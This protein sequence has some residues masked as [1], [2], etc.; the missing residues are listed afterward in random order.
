MSTLTRKW[1]SSSEIAQMSGFSDRYVRRA[2]CFD[3]WRV[4]RPGQH[5]H[6]KHHRFVNDPE[7]RDFCEY[8]LAVNLRPGDHR[9]R[10]WKRYAGKPG[11]GLRPFHKLHQSADDLTGKANAL[12]AIG[13]L[14]ELKEELLDAVKRHPGRD[15]TKLRRE[16]RKIGLKW[17]AMIREG[18][19]PISTTDIESDLLDRQR[20]VDRERLPA[21]KTPTRRDPYSPR[22][23]AR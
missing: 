10:Q 8:L 20:K 5:R 11:E 16:I 13:N 18:K 6:G 23:Y 15:E 1:L 19:L 9:G 4:G 2:R 17:Q 21:R 7:L 14:H 3:A 22:E 12:A